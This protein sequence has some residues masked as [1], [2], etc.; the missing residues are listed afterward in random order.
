MSKASKKKPNAILVGSLIAA[1]LAIICA[2]IVIFTVA[3]Q[4]AKTDNGITPEEFQ[5]QS[6]LE[7]ED[8]IAQQIKIKAD[9]YQIEHG[10]YAIY[11]EDFASTPESLKDFEYRS[12]GKKYIITYTSSVDGQQKTLVS[13]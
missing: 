9:L 8:A 1:A 6:S 10:Y 7:H 3:N 11:L 5:R 4:P 12:D 13:D 2:L